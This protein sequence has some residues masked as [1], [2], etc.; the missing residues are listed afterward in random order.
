M[1]KSILALIFFVIVLTESVF[2]Q[3]CRDASVELSAE[4]QSNPPRI[5]LNWVANDSATAHFVYRKLKT[6]NTWGA[7]VTTLAGSDTQFIDSTVS[8]GISYEY[9][10]VRQANAFVGY[11]YINSGINIAVVEKR[12]T[13]LLVVDSTFID[14][15]AFEISRL[16]HDFEGDGWQVVQLNVSRSAPVTLVKS[17]IVNAYNQDPA[18]TKA[19]FL[20]GRVPVPY[21]GEINVDGHAE[22]TGAYP[23]DVYYADMNGVW[24]DAFTNNVSAADPRNRNIPE[25]GKFDQSLIPSDLE[26]QIGRVDFFNMPSFVTSEQELLRN[27][28]DKDHA[29]RHKIFE[30]E[31]RALIDDNF[32]YFGGEA[33]AASG[34]RNAGPLVG[35]ENVFPGDYFPDMSAGSYL[36]SYGCGGGWYQGSGGVGTTTDFANSDLQSVFTMLFGSYFGDWDTPDNFLRAPL[37]SGRTLTNVWSGR[38]H[39]EFHHMGLGENIGYNVR[40]SQNNNALYTSNFGARVVHMAFMGDPTLRN[41]IV[42]PAY[43]VIASAENFHGNI[44]WTASTDSVEGYHLYRRK[45][46]S[47]EYIRVNSNLVEGNSFV[48]SCLVDT[49][50]YEYMVRAMKHERTPSGSYYNLSQGMTDT[51]FNLV[52]PSVIADATFSTEDDIVTF[53]N[54]STNAT[55]YLWLFGDG[56]SS[57]EQ[58]PVH[59]YLDGDFEA[60]LIAGNECDTDTHYLNIS[61]LT[62]THDASYNSGITIYPNPS[63]GALTISLENEGKSSIKMYSATGE[64]V[65]DKKHLNRI[66]RIDLKNVSNGIYFLSVICG[67]KHAIQKIIIQQ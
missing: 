57:N 56:Q 31:H 9:R 51:L 53:T 24:S 35:T 50:S 21:G 36:W 37:A 10:V 43:D 5:T 62:A 47:D 41:N 58:N 26:L 29:Y 38:P 61:I 19:V 12:G 48:D 49:G 15:L 34:W 30:A 39:W 67:E 44:S 8:E 25:D 7:L 28:L 60:T 27:Y 55:S 2:T 52:D 45:D 3:S 40:L 16:K 14:S 22:H 6:G 64:L 54:I 11:G 66:E 59:D 63:D 20:F 18:D 1:I 33:F 42:A 13:I 46:F 4:V 23:A 17:L 65:F 32:G